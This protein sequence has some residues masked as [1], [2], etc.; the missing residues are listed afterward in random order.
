MR[1]AHALGLLVLAVALVGLA[2]AGEARA[3]TADV[4]MQ[5]FA[6]QPATIEVRAGDSVRWTNQ[7]NAQHSAAAQDGSWNTGTFGRGSTGSRVFSTEGTFAYYCTVHPSM[8]GTVRV[9]AAAVNTPPTITMHEPKHGAV[10]SGGVLITGVAAD[11]DGDKLTVTV[12]VDG[13]TYQVASIT[14][15]AWTFSWNTRLLTNGD[16]SITARVTDGVAISSASTVTVNVQN[17]PTVTMGSPLQNATFKRG[18]RVS[19]SGS[20][21]GAPNLTL[22]V[23]VSIDGGDFQ[24]TLGPPSAWQFVWN[25]TNATLGGHTIQARVT[26]G[27][28]TVLSVIRNVTLIEPP[29]VAPNKPPVLVITAPQHNATVGGFVN[30]TGTATDPDGGLPGVEVDPDGRGW[31]GVTGSSGASWWYH[32]IVDGLPAGEVVVQARASDGEDQV[33]S[34]RNVTLIPT[35]KALVID[36][37]NAT[38]RTGRDLRVEVEIDGAPARDARVLVVAQNGTTLHERLA[39]REGQVVFPPLPRGPHT[40]R[41]FLPGA[42]GSLPIDVGPRY[43]ITVEP[44]HIAAGEGRPIRV[45]VFDDKPVSNV[46]VHLAGDILAPGSPSSGRTTLDGS[47]TIGYEVLASGDIQVWVANVDTGIRVRFEPI[48]LA[49]WTPEDPIV[50]DR[51]T[52]QLTLN[53]LARTPAARAVIEVDGPDGE[54]ERRVANETGAFTILAEEVGSL[55]FNATYGDVRPAAIRIPVAQKPAV[56]ALRE[57][58]S[59][60]GDSGLLVSVFVRN[61]GEGPGAFVVDAVASSAA[62]TAVQQTVRTR[63]LAPQEEVEARFLLRVGGGEYALS[64]TVRNSTARADIV[65]RMPEIQIPPAL[66]FEDDG[67]EIE[68]DAA[69]NETPVGL[70]VAVG[71]L[72]VAAWARRRTRT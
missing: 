56:P 53:D 46:P 9:I 44:L 18:D 37:G 48:L 63:E 7:D 71:A 5:G 67:P 43:D 51:V 17:P 6:F 28:T 30:I 58:T 3:E 64:A 35:T 59:R 24:A 60:P 25:T 16:H 23:G 54:T 62:G 21:T 2:L 10:V 52:V 26:D 1:H 66:T 22:S 38:A 49:T 4:A 20:A 65:A 36:L 34:T 14:D 13:G 11:A 19:V 31:R 72:G 32:W 33:F 61:D 12:R 40:L 70:G 68:E 57:L 42:A 41:A 55:R 15:G 45:S 39:T 27:T 29:P 69:A 47:M 8:T 50:G